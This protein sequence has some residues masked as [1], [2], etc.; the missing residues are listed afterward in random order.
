[1]NVVTDWITGQL[2]TSW[3][4]VGIGWAAFALIVWVSVVR[5][6]A[7]RARKAVAGVLAVVL[8]LAAPGIMRTLTQP[9]AGTHPTIQGAGTVASVADGDTFT[10]LGTDGTETTVRLLGIDAPEIAHDDNPSGCG[11]DAAKA[12]LLDILPHATPVTIVTD[13]VSDL[14][15]QYGRTLAYVA[16]ATVPDVALALIRGGWAEAWVPAGEPHNSR[17]IQYT[18]AAAA[19]RAARVGAWA[20]CSALGRQ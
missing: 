9:T 17:W 1:M 4:A 10:Y 2:L 16:T 15:D 8:V 14:V 5:R 6:V 20:T 19:A 12:A 18:Q 13:P 7:S 3:A 11:G